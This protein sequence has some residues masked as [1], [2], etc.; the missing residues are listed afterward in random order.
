[1]LGLIYWKTEQDETDEIGYFN[2][3]WKTI[4]LV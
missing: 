3:R 4:E 2:V 1:M